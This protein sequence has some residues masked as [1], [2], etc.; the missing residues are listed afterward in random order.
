MRRLTSPPPM[1]VTA[2]LV[3]LTLLAGVAH[4][5]KKTLV[6]ALN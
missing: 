6:V 5:Q 2:A 4:A 1:V 3:A